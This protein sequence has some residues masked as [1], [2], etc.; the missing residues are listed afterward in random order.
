VCNSFAAFGKFPLPYNVLARKGLYKVSSQIEIGGE[1]GRFKTFLPCIR[2]KIEILLDII[3][4]GLYGF[5]VTYHPDPRAF[6]TKSI[7]TRLA[8]PGVIRAIQIN[9]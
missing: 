6:R 7:I 5:T 1:V 8:L 3:R 4:E 2:Y 9:V